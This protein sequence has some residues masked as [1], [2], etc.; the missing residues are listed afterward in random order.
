VVAAPASV[1][2]HVHVVEDHPLYRA[3]LVAALEATTDVEV[4]IA[5]PSVEEFAAFRPAPGAVVTLD[6]K[7]PG[8]SDTEAVA[9]VVRMGFVVLVLS[10]YGARTDIVAAMAAGA[11]G[12][13]TKDADIDEIRRAVRAVAAGD[14]YVAP[15][16]AAHLLGTARQHNGGSRVTLSDRERQVLALLAGGDRDQDIAAALSISVRTVRSHLDRIREKTG[17]RRRS[18]LTRL[19]LE[20][21]LVMQAENL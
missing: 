12:Y 11:R 1:P 18:D 20:K 6:L 21:G 15:A 10:A 17:R 19:A 2:A 3:A 8:V 16:L 4:G 13:L 9:T 5:A 7:L 14:R